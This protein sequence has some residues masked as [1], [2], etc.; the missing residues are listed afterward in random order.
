MSSKKII[1][2]PVERLTLQQLVRATPSSIVAR[3]TRQCHLIRRQYAMG[4]L[5]GFRRQYGKN[6]SYYNEMRTWTT[7]TDGK[8]NSYLRF[9]GPPALQ[10]QVW[11][12]CDCPYFKF[13]CEVVLSRYN[14]STI[15]SSNGMLPVVRNKRMVPHLC[16]HLLI[17]AKYAVQEKRDLVQDELDRAA[18]EQEEVAGKK[19]AM[20]RPLASRGLTIPKGRFT[21]PGGKET[22]LVDL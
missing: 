17:A 1:A 15:R 7:C 2:A 8:R 9:F 22:G 16:K 6:R 19:A 10:T 11:A 5:D 13:Y 18:A 12:W 21:S 3:A 4:S 14:C 20:F